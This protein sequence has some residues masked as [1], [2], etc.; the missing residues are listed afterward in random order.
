MNDA[1]RRFL[2]AILLVGVAGISG[3]LLLMGHYE[4]FYQQIPLA[5]C[6]LSL[7]ALAAVL[8]RPGRST[9]TLFRVVMACFVLS[10][11]IGALLHFRR[12]S[13]SSWKW[14][15][16]CKAPTSTARRFWPNHRRRSRRGR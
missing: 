13:N 15:P 9:V 14:I 16:A 8:L 1:L 11:M 6:A 4:D 3:E 12:T 2:L 7:A 5:L 10:G